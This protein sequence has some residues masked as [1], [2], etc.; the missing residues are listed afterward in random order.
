M[1][2]ELVPHLRAEEKAFYP[3]LRRNAESKEDAL[4]AM[5]E[6]HAAELVLVELDKMSAQEEFW[7]AKL[8]VFREMVG[9]HIE[10]EEKKIFKDA[11]EHISEE[12]MDSVIQNFQKEKERVK[13]QSMAR[14][15]SK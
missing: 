9:H 14:S 4:E 2:Q 10:E 3:L 13:E 7:L 11:K 6:H 12:Q 8:S 1:K 15:H 5:E